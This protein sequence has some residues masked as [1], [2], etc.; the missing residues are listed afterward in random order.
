MNNSSTKP[1]TLNNQ[2]QLHTASANTNNANTSEN[3]HGDSVHNNS[4]V[5]EK[6]ETDSKTIANDTDADPIEEIREY[7]LK[8]QMYVL[9][10]NIY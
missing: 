9:L 10:R 2:S 6:E 1:D 8:Y 7:I 5:D 3:G 4:S